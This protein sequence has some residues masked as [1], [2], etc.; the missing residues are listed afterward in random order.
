M[1]LIQ[2][3]GGLLGPS[4]LAAGAARPENSVMLDGLSDQALTG[5]QTDPLAR[6]IEHFG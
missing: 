5:H 6:F 2:C 1:S 4:A 3:V